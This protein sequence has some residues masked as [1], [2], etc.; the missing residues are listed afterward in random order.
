MSPVATPIVPTRLL[1][2]VRPQAR[3]CKWLESSSPTKITC[4]LRLWPTSVRS[5]VLNVHRLNKNKYNVLNRDLLCFSLDNLVM[6]SSMLPVFEMSHSQ[7][8]TDVIVT[9]EAR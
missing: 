2:L 7:E 8:R 6:V 4:F 3:L 1:D 9:P 5:T